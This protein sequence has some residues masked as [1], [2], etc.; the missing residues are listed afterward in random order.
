MLEMVTKISQAEEKA[1]MIKKD[2]QTKGTEMENATLKECK[3]KLTLAF[4]ASKQEASELIKKAQA[5]AQASAEKRLETARIASGN[6]SDFAS[7]R[8]NQGATL[9]VERIVDIR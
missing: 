8:L 1:E 5:N 4:E 7:A 6:L 2:A 9:I 3:E